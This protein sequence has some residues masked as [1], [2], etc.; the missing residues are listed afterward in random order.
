MIEMW[1]YLLTPFSMLS[2]AIYE[3]N[4]RCPHTFVCVC[5]LSVDILCLPP[6]SRRTDIVM[7]L[8]ECGRHIKSGKW[9]VASVV[10]QVASALWQHVHNNFNALPEKQR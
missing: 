9:H 3:S 8:R 4:N 5:R 6:P 10:W 1:Q 2:S 7:Q